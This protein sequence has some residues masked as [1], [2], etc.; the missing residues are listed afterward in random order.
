MPLPDHYAT[1]GVAEDASQT[2]IKKAYRR[3]ARELHPDKNPGDKRAEERFKEVQAAYDTLGDE[4]KRKAYDRQRLDPYAGTGSPFEGFGQGREGRFYR[5]PDGTYVRVDTAGAGPEGDFIFEGGGLGDILGQMFGGGGFGRTGQSGARFT[6]QKAPGGRDIEAT[7]ALSF[8]E[9]LAGGKREVTLPTGETVRIDVPQGVRDGLRIRLRGRGEAGAGGQ[10]G[11]L[12]LTFS[13]APSARFS[14]EG[15]DLVV[16]ETVSAVEAMLGTTR[17]VQ[18]A[19][20]ERVRV[21]IPPGT[22]PG[23]RLR[24]R[25]QGVRTRAGAGDLYVDVAVRVPPLGEAAR[26]GLRAWAEQHGLLR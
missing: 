4:A 10:R 2:E 23:A 7:L 24:L 1:L 26:E 12:Y 6:R 21:R 14:R 3:L 19:Y 11:D 18:T 8:E 20:G 13:V 17:E 22:Q 5:A 16:T 25:G 15:D 9:A